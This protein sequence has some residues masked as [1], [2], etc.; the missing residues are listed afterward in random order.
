MSGWN[1]DLTKEELDSM[2]RAEQAR[3]RARAKAKPV[4]CSSCERPLETSDDMACA[5]LCFDCAHFDEY[6]RALGVQKGA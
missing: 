2:E 6:M 3:K 5:P 4:Y 1:P